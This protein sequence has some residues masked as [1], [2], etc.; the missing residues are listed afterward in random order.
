MKEITL[1]VY[2]DMPAAMKRYL[3]YYGW[4]FSKAACMYAISRM[5][6][7]N[8][9]GKKERHKAVSKE[10]VDEVLKRHNIE[11]ENGELYDKVY[12]YNMVMSDY[13]GHGVDDE[14]HA[15]MLTKAILDDP[16]KPGGNV[17]RHWEAD[18]RAAGMG[19]EFDDLMD[20][21]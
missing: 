1:D 19:I 13:V 12:V 7:K 16:D 17:F 14:K 3:R 2:D 5:W 20:D 18:M 8:S 9:D 11:I 10:Q 15:A 21:D 6:K 4:H